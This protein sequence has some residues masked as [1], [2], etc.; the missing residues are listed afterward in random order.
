LIV[1]TLF[2]I[3]LPSAVLESQVGFGNRTVDFCVTNGSTKVVIE[4]FGPYHYIRR[5][6]QQ[7]TPIHPEIRK[8]QVEDFFGCECVVWP[9]WIQRCTANVKAIF[10]PSV[11]GVASIWSTSAQF[12]DFLFP[13]SAD[14]I[15]SSTQRFG[16]VR[17]GLG[18]IYGNDVVSKPVH[19]IV[20]RIRQGRESVSRLLPR[21]RSQPP[22][23]WLPKDLWS[24]SG[25]DH[26]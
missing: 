7:R 15:L 14:V 9:Y 25:A 8:Q 11:H 6:P 13:D 24:L 5:N 10:E 3:A 4:F 17:D 19:P 22:E 12:G 26:G 1:L 20:S 2:E 23:F 18:Y 21:G 16:A